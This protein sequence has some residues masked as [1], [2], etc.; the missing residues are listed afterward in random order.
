[1]AFIEVNDRYEEWLR[2]V[3]D[4]DE[5]GLAR[6]H[7]KMADSPFVFLRATFF[8][9][10]HSLKV[11]APDL[12]PAPAPLCL[13]DAHL[14]NFGTWRDGEGRLV[15]GL[16]DFDDAAEIPYTSDLARLAV[17]IR[18]A[19]E[20]TVGNQAA[21]EALL[22]GYEYGLQKPHPTLLDENEVWMRDYVAVSDDDRWEFW[23]EI[24]KNLKNLKIDP[25]E[26]AKAALM[27]H[28]PEGAGNEH[29][30]KRTKGGGS[31]GRPRFIV[32]A[33]WRG[34]W[35]V[36]EA[37]TLVASGWHWA[38]D[39]FDQRPQFMDAA[40]ASTRSP[41]PFL[42]VDG[43]FIL[44]RVTADT[45]KVERTEDFDRKLDR[46]LVGVMGF[47]LG[48]LHAASTGLVD[49]ISDDLRKRPAGWLGECAKSLAAAVEEDYAAWLQ[50]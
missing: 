14:E 49:A 16:N 5:D 24:E 23:K 37:K 34:G 30:A 44:R 3:C 10:A 41:D 46:R 38:H 7:K 17:S 9:W 8:R 22:Q 32:V 28:L 43:D 40:S 6:K 47:E 39:R 18:L 4:V 26:D 45:R 20:L 1:V 42:T 25:P 27:R 19:G 36:R 13:G 31:L 12:L 50:R 2:S 15:W 48:A 33:K 21:A 35:I 11:A 29:F